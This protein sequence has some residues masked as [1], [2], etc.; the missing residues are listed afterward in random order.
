MLN[1]QYENLQNKPRMVPFLSI[2]LQALLAYMFC[3]GSYTVFGTSF[4]LGNVFKIISEIRS[5]GSSEFLF[6]SFATSFMC[7]VYIGFACRLIFNVLA[8]WH[9]SSV[10]NKLFL[11][12]EV[13]VLQAREKLG[14]L[15][16]ATRSSVYC[17]LAFLCYT[18]LVSAYM[19]PR[20]MI[21]SLIVILLMC[22]LLEAKSF[23]YVQGKRGAFSFGKSLC[24]YL[25][26]VLAVVAVAYS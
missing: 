13:D 2:A 8:S 22:A 18:R 11:A 16:L 15:V 26:A 12:E 25:L 21:Q 24:G 1:T 10:I 17:S 20:S 19:L 23:S 14:K 3:S 7:I 4:K 5:G 9:T 6:Q